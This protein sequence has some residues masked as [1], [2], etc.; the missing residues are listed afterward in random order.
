MLHFRAQEGALQKSCTDLSLGNSFGVQ[1][2]ALGTH[3]ILNFWCFLSCAF[4]S[5]SLQLVTC[6]QSLSLNTNL[7]LSG[8]PGV[9]GS[10][11]GA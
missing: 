9:A 4:V 2:V 5:A 8:N 1:P 3:L 11:T 7:L 6:S 10:L